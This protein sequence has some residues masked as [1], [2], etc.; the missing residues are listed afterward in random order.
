[1]SDTDE[2]EGR[3]NSLWVIV[4]RVGEKEEERPRLGK[5]HTRAR[6]GPYKDWMEKD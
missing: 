4:I 6:T 5:R 3:I 2:L 1:M